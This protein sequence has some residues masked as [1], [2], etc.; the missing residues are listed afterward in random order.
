MVEAA[1]T[2]ERVEELKRRWHRGEKTQE[3]GLALGVSKSAVAG[4]ARRYDLPLRRHHTGT[5]KAKVLKSVTGVE[6]LQINQCRW[7]SGDPGSPDFSFCG[8]RVARGRSY[9]PA[10]CKRAYVTSRD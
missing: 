10:H 6:E 9:C 3:I 7:P 2:D 4:A 1:W 5:A 8:E